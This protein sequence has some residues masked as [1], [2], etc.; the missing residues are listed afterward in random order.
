MYCFVSENGGRWCHSHVALLLLQTAS[1]PDTFFS[2]L[3]RGRSLKSICH[4]CSLPPGLLLFVVPPREK[5]VGDGDSFLAGWQRQRRDPPSSRRKPL[6]T[7]EQR[8]E[9]GKKVS[10]SSRGGSGRGGQNKLTAEAGKERGRRSQ[11]AP[12]RRLLR[13]IRVMRLLLG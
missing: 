5:W 7:E 10:S 9:D 12:L 2:V 1:S 11:L 6:C 3:P 8:Q 13:R 4:P